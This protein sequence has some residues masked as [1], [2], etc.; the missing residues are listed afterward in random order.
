[1]VKPELIPCSI[2]DIDRI[3]A[4]AN[5]IWKPAFRDMLPPDRLD[6]L[7]AHMYNREKIVQQLKSE[8]HRFYILCLGTV[9]I[10]Y[11]QLIF[12][13]EYVKLEKLYVD[14]KE[15]GKKLGYFCL[16]ELCELAKASGAGKLR[17]Q[18]NRGN[19]KAIAFYLKFGFY[20]LESKDFEVGNGHVMD[21][22]VMEMRID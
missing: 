4:L 15:Q 13:E 18:V 1:M 10:G 7:F 11:A 14:Q 20:I 9:D 21:D 17:L 3:L 2:E 19:E 8:N 12:C 16:T 5:R 6:Y 22:Y